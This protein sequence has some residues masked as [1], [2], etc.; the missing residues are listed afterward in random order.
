MIGP[1]MGLVTLV[2]PA[3]DEGGAIAATLRSLPRSTLHAAGY[4]TEV[5][6][7]DGHSKDETVSIA[8]SLGAS[9]LPD[10]G[11]GKG[12]ALREARSAFQGDFVVMLDGDGTYAPDA[13]PRVLALLASGTADVVMGDRVALDGSMSAVHRAGNALLSLGATI[14]YGRRVPDLCTGLWGFRT[15]A[16]RRLPLMSDGFELEAELFAL[17]ARL[18]LR[19]RHTSVDYLPRTGASKLATRDGLRIGWCLLRNRFAS[20][21]RRIVPATPSRLS[22]ILPQVDAW[23]AP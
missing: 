2:V 5:I 19:V 4:L 18:H 23:P 1:G 12:S 16:L 22:E 14:L 20:V 7:L 13:I 15:D 3:K 17:S 21:R 6:V 10:R 9:V 11:H 8:R